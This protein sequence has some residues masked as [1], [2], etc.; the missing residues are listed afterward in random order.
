MPVPDARAE[1][2]IGGAWT[3]ATQH[4]VQ[5]TGV[6]LS[7]GRSDEGRPV[8]PGSGSLTL[9]SPNGL[10]SN[11]NPNS[12]YFER[13]P[14]N[15]TVRVSCTG[16]TPALLVPEGVAG[17]ASTPD[18]A[19][20]DITG[21]I[22]VR[23]ELDPGV[24]AG[25]GIGYE[26]LSK[27]LSTGNQRSWRLIYTGEGQIHFAWSADGIT[28]NLNHRSPVLGSLHG[29]RAIRA[30][31][32]V[33][34]GLGGY[35]VTYY[36][37]PTLAG[38]WTQVGQTVT[39][40]GTTSVYSSSAALDVGDA[41]SLSLSTIERRIY[42]AE[43]RSGIGGAIVAAPDFTVQAPGTTSF[44]DSVGRS[45]TVTDGAS[46]DDRTVRA[47]HV[48]PTWPATWHRSGGDVRAPISTAG[49]LRR[50][51]Q[52]RKELASTLRRR[53][54]SYLPLAY[55]PCED[56]SDATQAGSPIGGVAPLRV[57]GWAFN[58]DSSLASSAALP[59]VEAG[60]TMVGVVPPP[61]GH[62]LLWPEWSVHLF[63]RVDAAPGTNQEIFAWQT[64]G[65]LKRWRVWLR[66]GIATL[67]G[68]DL[69]GTARIDQTVAIGADVFEGWQRLTVQA[70]QNPSTSQLDWAIQ[71]TNI[72][73]A[74]GGVSG[75]IGEFA[76]AVTRISTSFGT[77]SG[78]RVGHITALPVGT[79][80]GVH[81]PFL[82]A[83][84]AW[85]GETAVARLQR[86][87]EEE[88]QTLSLSTWHADLTDTST[89]LGP[90][91]PGALLDV[92]QEAAD[93]DGGILYE[94]PHRLALTYR[95][96]STLYNQTPVVI[97]YSSLT[98]PFEP[99]ESDLRLRNDVTVER[100]G[101]SSARAVQQTGPLSVDE[102]GLY[103]E[104]VTLS[105]ETD[106]QASQIAYWRLHMGTWDEARYP[107]VRIML[108]R[109]PELI[110]E[111]SALRI[112]DRVQITGTPSWMPPGPVDLIVQRIGEDIKT[113]TWD[114]VL[115]CS[116]GAPWQVGVFNSTTN[117]RANTSGSQL[118]NAISDSATSFS[119]TTTVG[120]RWTVDPAQFPLPI[121]VGGEE[122]TVTGISG[123]SSPQTF[124][125]TRSANG[126]VKSHAAGAPVAVARPAVYAL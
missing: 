90:Q 105:L 73:G 46:I 45:W 76:G 66:S 7:S 39:T 80:N 97:P 92:L 86:L 93:A 59:A 72:G 20:L 11:R 78:L 1:L 49:I 114:V 88:S 13:L 79:G 48:V 27:Y 109:H 54:P 101:G 44:T 32:D 25:R 23:V 56:G 53:I 42:R 30:T 10:Y 62:P 8:D 75:S 104:S 112:G 57:T 117:G 123:T 17:R 116:P 43:V 99:D 47:A 108:H 4:V 103:D 22:D 40:S 69:D 50:L 63:Y 120:V 51:G 81:D 38:P 60:G 119:V 26:L 35:T 21:D 96:R 115:T 68:L 111:V 126:I 18:H 83:E 77:F 52:G 15:V 64:D 106:D 118:T 95:A 67:Q 28:V 3:E 122:M 121:T 37:A 82:G 89:A 113:F 70:R 74:A 98:T 91:R 125:V 33:N 71:W 65:S 12:P 58:S 84:T 102:V 87:A 24:W 85:A 5:S 9:L 100:S 124:T 34:N 19:S 14:R 29:R 6:Q 41:S 55:W 61:A 36:T 2:Q 94:D 107:Q 110:P 16:A 31:L